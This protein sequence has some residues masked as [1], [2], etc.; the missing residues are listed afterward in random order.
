MN[1]N[2]SIHRDTIDNRRLSSTDQHSIQQQQQH[3]SVLNIQVVRSSINNNHFSSTSNAKTMTIDTT[4]STFDK[5][6]SV[7]FSIENEYSFLCIFSMFGEHVRSTNR[8]KYDQRNNEN[9][10]ITNVNDKCS[11]CII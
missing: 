10:K 2:D 8:F 9:N 7:L 11:L 5:R 1:N 6:R 4:L 3:R